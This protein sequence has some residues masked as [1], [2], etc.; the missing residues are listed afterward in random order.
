MAIKAVIFDIDGVLIDSV[1]SNAIFFE[2][3]FKSVGGIKY[4]R[5][6]YTKRNHMTM[7]DI[8]KYFTKEKSEQKI[9]QIW[10][11]AMK[12]RYSHEHIKLPKDGIAV[13]K[14]LS[15]SYKLA[16]VT[17]RQTRGVSSINDYKNPKPHPE[18]LLVAL[19]K[20]KVKAN[21]AVYIGDMEA[22]I[23]CAKR[24][25]VYSILFKRPYSI[26]KRSKPDF[27]VTSFKKIPDMIHKL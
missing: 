4:S 5:K 9:R 26:L 24:T 27:I 15:L 13:L 10:R 19:R 21:E 20:L 12:S 17:A 25:G 6:E 14:T 7:W 2:K 22:D 16:V 18:P 23:L 1:K 3:L 11:L 8:I